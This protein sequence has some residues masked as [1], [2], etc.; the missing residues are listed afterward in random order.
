MSMS[1]PSN[2]ATPPPRSRTVVFTVSAV[3]VAA[4]LALIAVVAVTFTGGSDTA[5]PA[6]GANGSEAPRL[7]AVLVGISGLGAAD[8]SGW[9]TCY[10]RGVITSCDFP[11]PTWLETETMVQVPEGTIVR[12]EGTATGLASCHISETDGVVLDELTVKA[13]KYDGSVT[14]ECSATVQ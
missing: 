8:Q 6:A 9:Y 5:G 7:V 4:V 12:V 14:V 3:V 11:K 2:A 13:D 1:T 10:K